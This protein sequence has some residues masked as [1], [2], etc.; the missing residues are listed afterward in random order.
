[1]RKR[2]AILGSTGSIGILTLDVI[3]EFRERFE[4]KALSAFKNYELLLSQA[5]E[6][7][8]KRVCIV[9]R[10]SYEKAKT[11]RRAKKFELLEGENGI[12]EIAIDSESEIIVNAI[13]GS[14]G[15]LATI[16][17]LEAGKRVCLANKESLVC[18]GK[19]IVELLKKKG[20]LFPID[21]EHSAVFQA[22]KAGKHSE[23]KR[24][25]LTASGGP[26]WQKK[27][28]VELSPDEAVNHPRWRMGKKISVDSATM[29]NKGFELIEAHWLFGLPY[30]KID[31]LIHPESIVH[32][33]VEFV[34][35]SIISQLSYPDMRI[36][37]Q[38]ALLYPERLNSK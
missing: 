21:S 17:A 29:L 35:N 8:V 30:E 32:S 15:L 26:L 2:V 22:M 9:D 38:Y 33:L 27:N 25:I 5:E 12:I 10:E 28:E 16:N 7:G 34:D 6:F 3:R 11:D 23:L 18:A 14:G 20:E 19:Y 24:I 1:M 36:P 37:I 4:I 31:V 13:V